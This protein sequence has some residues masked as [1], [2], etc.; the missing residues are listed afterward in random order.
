MQTVSINGTGC[1]KTG[2]GIFV[3]ES[4]DSSRV[5]QTVSQSSS[6]PLTH[7][8]LAGGACAGGALRNGTCVGLDVE[9]S[10]GYCSDWAPIAI[11]GSGQCGSAE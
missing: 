11:D 4:S 1:S 3:S 6:H 8:Q 2:A 7:A 5:T 10:G 9:E